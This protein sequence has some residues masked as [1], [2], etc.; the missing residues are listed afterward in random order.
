MLSCG[1]LYQV[2][3]WL[4]EW[5][6]GFCLKIIVCSQLSFRPFINLSVAAMVENKI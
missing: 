6:V 1:Q 4:I 2:T 5:R 3:L